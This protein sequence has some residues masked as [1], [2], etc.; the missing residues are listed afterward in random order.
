MFK[1]SYYCLVAGLPDLFFNENKTGIDSST[2]RSELKKELNENDFQLARLL[3]L[4][5]DNQNLLTLL[6]QPEKEFIPGGNFTRPILEEQITQPTD[7][8]I[9]MADFM[10]WVKNLEIKTRFPE[11][12]NTLLSLFYQYVLSINNNTFIREWF[13]FD[14]NLRNVLTAL[15]CRKFNYKTENQLIKTK[16]STVYD[17]LANNRFKADLFEEEMSCADIIFRI[18]EMDKSMI[19]KEKMI[20]TLKWNWLDEHTFFHYFTIEKILGFILKLQ[21][22]ERWIKLDAETGKQLLQ[23]LLNELKT[24]YTFPAEFSMVK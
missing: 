6:F 2:F 4:P 7:L 20:D 15:N 3:F 12:E 22:T 23:K 18:A 10:G 19:E 8:P 5:V 11:A 17:L 16:Q 1:K 14:L 9:Y 13:S 21:I 24:S